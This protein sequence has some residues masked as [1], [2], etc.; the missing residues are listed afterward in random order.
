LELTGSTDTLLFVDVDGVL[1]VGVT[2]ET[3]DC[4]LLT[5]SNAKQAAQLVKRR[6]AH[7]FNTS[8]QRFNAVWNRT[9]PHEAG[10]TYA[11]LAC[12][13]GRETSEVLTERLARLIELAGDQRMVVLS[14]SWRRRSR[15]DKVRELEL[16]LSDHL[17]EDFKFDA[18]TIWRAENEAADRLRTIGDFVADY[19]AKQ[20]MEC[21]DEVDE[22][23]DNLNESEHFIS[24]QV[25]VLILEDFFASGLSGWDCDGYRIDSA[26]AAQMYIQ[27]RAPFG[28]Q[29]SAKLI[30]TYDE[31]VLP[32]GPHVG[33]RFGVGCGLTRKHYEAAVRF[34]AN[35]EGDMDMWARRSSLTEIEDKNCIGMSCAGLAPLGDII[36]IWNLISGSAGVEHCGGNKWCSKEYDEYCNCND[37]RDALEAL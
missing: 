5:E 6:G 7:S 19:C 26:M 1:N 11:S 24:R 23:A 16:E 10:Q 8:A 12:D 4:L 21:V 25:R 27:S 35:S 31:L 33:S 30:H 17:G 18:T 13:E 14:S 9:L 28:F 15:A 34:L 22:D 32:M 3:G 2:E 20:L 29:V 36:K 37:Y